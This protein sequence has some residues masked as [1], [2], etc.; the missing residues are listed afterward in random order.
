MHWQ[1]PIIDDIF[2][3]QI[4]WLCSTVSYAASNYAYFHSLVKIFATWKVTAVQLMRPTAW[5][6]C[7]VIHQSEGLYTVA[8]SERT[9]ER[10]RITRS[11][12]WDI[13]GLVQERRSSIANALELHLSCTNPSIWGVFLELRVCRCFILVIVVSC[14]I[15]CYN[16]LGINQKLWHWTSQ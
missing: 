8:F 10:H 5:R 12:G 3:T 2:S 13:D 15:L 1:G 6:E 9:H 16:V 14:V 4:G 11:L 7:W